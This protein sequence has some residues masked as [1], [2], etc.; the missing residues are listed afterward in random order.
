MNILKKIG[1]GIFVFFSTVIDLV[2]VVLSTLLNIKEISKC[3]FTGFIYPILITLVA[4][5]PFDKRISC[6]LDYMITEGKLPQDLLSF[7]G[8]CVGVLFLTILINSVI[9]AIAYMIG[10]NEEFV[11]M[12]KMQKSIG[13]YVMTILSLA[14]LWVAGVI[15]KFDISSNY[16]LMLFAFGTLYLL[17]SFFCDIYNYFV[18]SEQ[19]I[20]SVCE[21][22]KRKIDDK[23]QDK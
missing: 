23:D 20:E 17:S 19:K 12:I 10:K 16:N 14:A 21:R 5:Y 2:W 4:I 11:A 13:T 22:L 6:F 7:F 1:K 9:Q 18:M 8:T 15:S 3:V